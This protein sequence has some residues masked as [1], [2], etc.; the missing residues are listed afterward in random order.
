VRQFFTSV[1]VHRR[2][3]KTDFETEPYEVAWASEAICFVRVESVSGQNAKLEMFAQISAD[4]L[5]WIDEGTRFPAITEVGN[6][7]VRLS[8][9]GG[10]LRFRGTITGKP[11]SFTLTIHLV[12]KE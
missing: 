11:V 5:R 8:H 1:L 3:F 10:W 12:L 4:G 9:F 2:A 6:Y 7:F